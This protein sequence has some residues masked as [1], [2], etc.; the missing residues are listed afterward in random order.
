VTHT[1]AKMRAEWFWIDRWALSSA[2]Q[3]PIDMRGLYREMLTAAWADDASL[4]NDPAAIKRMVAVTDD[5]WT[6]CWPFVKRYWRERD[7][8]RLVN[9]TQLEVYRKQ[10]HLRDARSEASRER[11]TRQRKMAMHPANKRDASRDATP[12]AKRHA[13]R[14]TKRI[15]L[16]LDLDLDL[17]QKP[18]GTSTHSRARRSRKK[19]RKPVEKSKRSP[20]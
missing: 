20:S 4:P 5:E 18:E 19:T 3:L 11:W 2:R 17:K 13:K 16:D 14:S 10:L 12:N 1:V 8:G 7:D 9:D 15:D 6:R